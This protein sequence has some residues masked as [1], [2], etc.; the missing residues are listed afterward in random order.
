MTRETLDWLDRET[1]IRLVL[2]QAE[3]IAVATLEC[4]ALGARAA[5]LEARLDLPGKTPGNSSTPPSQGAKASGEE[6]KKAEGEWRKA[7]P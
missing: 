2:T 1:L 6:K 5:E 4:E 7:H 3:T